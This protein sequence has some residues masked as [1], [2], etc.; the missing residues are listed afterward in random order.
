LSLS[1]G[2][3]RGFGVARQ[4]MLPMREIAQPLWTGRTDLLRRICF[5]AA[6][7]PGRAAVE[8]AGDQNSP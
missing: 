4:A 2:W 3:P 6:A 7:Q 5:G 8:C 1:A